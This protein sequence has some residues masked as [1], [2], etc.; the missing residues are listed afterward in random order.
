MTL[1]QEAPAEPVVVVPS[2]PTRGPNR[3]WRVFQVT[4]RWFSLITGIVLLL[5]ILSGAILVLAPEID[6]WTQPELYRSTDERAHAHARAGGRVAQAR[7]A[8]LRARRR[9]APARH[10]RDLR[11]RVRQVGLRGPGHRAP[12]R[13]RRPPVGRDGLP[14]QPAPVRLELRGLPGLHPVPGQA[15]AGARQRGADRRRPDPRRHRAD[16]DLPLHQRPRDLVAGP[17]PLEAR[18]HR[19]AG[20]RAP[21]SS[22]TTCTTWSAS[23]CC[24]CC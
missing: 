8:G 3:T 1:Q 7:R 10:L 11:P 2:R 6:E 20:A 14:A 13:H 23:P 22:T 24:R 5:I 19:S 21:T 18:L 16:P 12:E 9:R 17:A 4:H 15:G